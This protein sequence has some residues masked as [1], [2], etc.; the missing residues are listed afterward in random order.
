MCRILSV[1]FLV[2]LLAACGGCS[3][4]AHALALE[5][6][7][8]VLGA[9]LQSSAAVATATTAPT[10]TATPVSPAPTFTRVPPAATSTPVRPAPTPQPFAIKDTAFEA[11]YTGDC[12]T[13]ALIKGV[14]GTSFDV[15]GTVSMRDGRFTLWCWGAKHTWLGTLTYAGYTF[16]SDKAAPLQFAVTANRGYLYTGGKG[17]VT[18][19]DGSRVILPPGVAPAPSARTPTVTPVPPVTI[20]LSAGKY[21]SPLWLEVVAGAYKLQGGTTLR[22]G[23]ALG[24]QEDQL[25]F[26][27]SLLI[28]VGE[29][30]VVLKGK[31]LAQ[32]TSFTV[33]A[34]GNLQ[35]GASSAT[36]AGSPPGA[37][38]PQATVKTANLNIR[39][40]PGTNYPEGPPV[41]RRGLGHRRGPVRNAQRALLDCA[42]RRGPAHAGATAG[43]PCRRRSGQCRPVHHLRAAWSPIVVIRGHRG[44][45]GLSFVA[46]W[47][48]PAR[49]IRA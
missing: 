30:P 9:D 14:D 36:P 48:G 8:A 11:D 17:T 34:A 13:D 26:P 25:T 41:G 23:S 28:N 18:L 39:G 40:G 46:F 2:V 33:D 3:Q 45:A 29:G 38:T 42:C 49:V 43:G 20:R 22:T 10:S 12:A 7:V 4:P 31:S 6:A 21:G 1:L 44:S 35:P 24:V 47:A 15:S 37:S 5:A 32:G 16:A 27:P 19:P